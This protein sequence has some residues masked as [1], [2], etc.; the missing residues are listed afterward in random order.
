MKGSIVITIKETNE[1]GHFPLTS[2]HTIERDNTFESIEDWVDIFKKI[3]YMQG[4]CEKTINEI[5]NEEEV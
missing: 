3:L 1:C 2:V 5:F 4:F